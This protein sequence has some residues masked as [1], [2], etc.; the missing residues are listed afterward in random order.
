MPQ[1]DSSRL[2]VLKFLFKELSKNSLLFKYELQRS[3]VRV[4]SM[5]DEQIQNYFANSKPRMH[6]SRYD[7]EIDIVCQ[8]DRFF[9]ELP[10]QN[11]FEF[12]KSQT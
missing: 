7:I 2:G 5:K 3:K 1:V 11:M 12:Y 8:S 9:E 10:N 6:D 4:S